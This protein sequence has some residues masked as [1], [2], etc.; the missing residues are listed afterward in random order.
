MRHRGDA[1]GTGKARRPQAVRPCVALVA[2]AGVTLL[3][4]AACNTIEGVGK[5]VKATG[6]A[7][8]KA[9]GSAKRP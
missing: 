2:A 7:I 1:H 3:G 6:S 9:A 5:D 4:L 8:E